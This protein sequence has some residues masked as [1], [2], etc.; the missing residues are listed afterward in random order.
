MRRRDAVAILSVN[1]G[2]L[3]TALLAAEAVGVAAPINPALAAGPAAEL[4]RLSGAKVIV[5]AGP[6]LDGKVWALARRLAA[7]TGARAL[8]ALRPPL[9]AEGPALE[10]LA[11]DDGRL[12]RD[13]RRGR[14]SGRRVCDA[15]EAGDLASYIHTGG[16][17]GT[18]KLAARTHRNEVANAWMVARVFE[19]DDVVFAALPLFHTNAIVVTLLA[20]LLRGLHVVWAGPLGYRDPSLFGVFWK[21]VARHRIAVM[22][23]VPTVYAALA[24][25]RSTR[26]SAACGCRSSAPHRFRRGGRGVPRADGRRPLRGLR[27]DR[28]HVRH[29]V[30]GP[31]AARAGDRRP[32]PAVPAG[33]CRADRPGVGPVAVLPD[34]EVGTL[35]VKGPNVFAGY[36]VP[37][38]DG[39]VPRRGGQGARRLARHGR[40]RLVDADGYIRLA[41]RA[42]DLII[43]GGHNIDP[44]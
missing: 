37:G 36:L 6:E 30:H 4:V 7:A 42:K 2:E 39:P 11:G 3:I 20:P 21:L 32:A 40:P 33:A 35:V 19:D 43:R 9:G 24:R 41:G 28:G 29:R 26:T 17:T 27:P 25:C 23:G 18:P 10:P 34:G 1:C 5:A 38:P 31:G 15:P 14:V 16:T 44:L 22:S 8:L 12:P 13:A